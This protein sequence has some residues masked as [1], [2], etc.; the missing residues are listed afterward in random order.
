MLMYSSTVVS[1]CSRGLCVAAST[2][3]QR[4]CSKL[5]CCCQ[6]L[7]A[8]SAG[9]STQTDLSG[10]EASHTHPAGFTYRLQQRHHMGAW[11][12][13]K[14]IWGKVKFRSRLVINTATTWRPLTNPHRRLTSRQLLKCFFLCARKEEE[15]ICER[16]QQSDS[17]IHSCGTTWL[18]NCMLE[19]VGCSS[20]DTTS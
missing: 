7:R 6:Y 5:R 9:P 17:T 14:K 2:I 18:S 4:S 19:P 20:S 10:P 16:S 13:T 8:S 11:K 1:T 12:R 15:S 3:L